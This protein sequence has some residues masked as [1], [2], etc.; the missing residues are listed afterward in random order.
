[1]AADHVDTEGQVGVQAEMWDLMAGLQDLPPFCFH[2]SIYLVFL[3]LAMWK[4]SV[5][6]CGDS[7]GQSSPSC[8]QAIPAAAAPEKVIAPTVGKGGV[9]CLQLICC[10]H[11]KGWNSCLFI[12]G[13]FLCL[14]NFGKKPEHLSEKSS[15]C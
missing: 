7:R 12:L 6:L 5:L 14:R 8:L 10:A 2:L 1:M 13:N 4:H 15:Y 3:L 11:I 9:T